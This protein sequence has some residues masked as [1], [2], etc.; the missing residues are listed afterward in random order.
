M[1]IDVFIV[2]VVLLG[3]WFTGT[4][5][6]GG[7]DLDRLH[8]GYFL[9]TV[10]GGLVASAGAAEVG[11]QRLAQFMLGLGILCWIIVGSMILGRLIFRPPLPD[12]LAPTMAIE[13]APA[14]VASVA[15]FFSHGARITP[16]VTALA[17]YGLL[18]VVAQIPLLSRYVRL[19][20]S[21]A[22]WA[23]TF[24]W[25]AVAST[26][27][28]WIEAEHVTRRPGLR[29]PGAGRHQ[30]AGRRH[31]CP[32]RRGHLPGSPASTAD[33]PDHRSL[34]GPGHEPLPAGGC[35]GQLALHDNPAVST[36]NIKENPTMSDLPNI[37]L[38]HGA[39][40][41]GSCWSTVIERLQARGY[42][43]TAPQF[44]ESSLA[45]DVARLRQV[46]ARQNGPTVVAGHSYGGQIMTALGTD[47][48]NA[49]ALV[50]IAAF[51]LDEGE[52]IGALLAVGSSDP[53]TRQ[54]RHRRARLCVVAEGRF[55]QPFC[56]RRRRGRSEC[57]VRR[58]ATALDVH[59]RRRDG[60]PGLEVAADV[61]HG[62]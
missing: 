6:R 9:P 44:P 33:G 56:S 57:H 62:R 5:M 3:G 13:V 19:K 14:A 29:L 58:S 51:G 54:P 2:G 32:H 50:Y 24:S 31:R 18:M 22:T 15:Y 46:L 20:F 8:P 11:Q 48:P 45:D 35:C 61:V 42:D 38:V 23:F 26:L 7:T 43:V 1:I 41:D 40:A 53:G 52:S 21:L 4:W 27:L 12:A 39:W 37:V 47:A 60:R 28:F 17:G 10:A 16:F 34:T 55:R 59:P 36:T 30:R 25:A 49:V